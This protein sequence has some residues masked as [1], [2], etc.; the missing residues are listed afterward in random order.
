[1]KEIVHLSA[2]VVQGTPE[3]MIFFLRWD[4]DDF[5]HTTVLHFL[6]CFFGI[7]KRE[8][9]FLRIML[10]ANVL[11]LL[12]PF[13]EIE[14]VLGIVRSLV[15]PSMVCISTELNLIDLIRN[16]G[17]ETYLPELAQEPLDYVVYRRRVMIRAFD[18]FLDRGDHHP[19]PEILNSPWDTLPSGLEKSDYA[20][21]WTS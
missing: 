5:K 16:Y 1:M 11:G 8:S 6:H 19:F 20:S 10:D 17:L 14:G 3:A 12:R 21:F 13:L 15:A 18:I 2:L 7:A 9:R 4:E